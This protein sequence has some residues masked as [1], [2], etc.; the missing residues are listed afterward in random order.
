MLSRTIGE[1]KMNELEN[2]IAWLLDQLDPEFIRELENEA[3]KRV[4]LIA[5]RAADYP[6]HI[7]HTREE[8]LEKFAQMATDYLDQ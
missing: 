2:F 8:V 7:A 1:Y 6:D 3:D 5:T 4:D